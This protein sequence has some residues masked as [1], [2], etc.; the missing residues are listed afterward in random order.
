[1]C[2]SLKRRISYRSYRNGIWQFNSNGKDIQRELYDRF[3]RI[4]DIR[5]ERK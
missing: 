5:V 4:E 1:M 2:R 3:H